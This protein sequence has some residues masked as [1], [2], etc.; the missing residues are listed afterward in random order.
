M[1]NDQLGDLHMTS[2][3]IGD[4]Y[5]FMGRELEAMEE[6]PAGNIVGVYLR[7]SL[8]REQS[9]YYKCYLSL[10]R[11]RRARRLHTQVCYDF[12]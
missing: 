12:Q 8:V 7:T 10:C 1:T 11:Y 4:L 9:V 2:V 3:S 6:V 5:T